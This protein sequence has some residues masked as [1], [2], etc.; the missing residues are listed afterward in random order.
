LAWQQGDQIGRL[1]TVGSF[2]WKMTELC[3]SH[4]WATL[5]LG[6]S[7]VL[8]LSKIGLGYF[9]GDYFTNSSGRPDSIFNVVYMYVCTL[10]VRIECIIGMCLSENCCIATSSKNMYLLTY[11]FEYYL[12]SRIPVFRKTWRESNPGLTYIWYRS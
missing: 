7:Y 5:F 6:K 1:F 4:S 9:L 10:F 12:L 11:E 8:I 3:S 2:F